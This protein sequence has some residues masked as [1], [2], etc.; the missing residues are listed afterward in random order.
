MSH[1]LWSLYKQLHVESC[2]QESRAKPNQPTLT[3]V[4]LKHFILFF[5][6]V[7]GG[8]HQRV[9]IWSFSVCFWH[10]CLCKCP[11]V[12]VIISNFLSAALSNFHYFIFLCYCWPILNRTN[13][14]S[15]LDSLA[16]WS[17]AA[18]AR[19]ATRLRMFIYTCNCVY[20]TEGILW[21]SQNSCTERISLWGTAYL[22]SSLRM[23][24]IWLGLPKGS[25]STSNWTFKNTTIIRRDWTLL[26]KM[27]WKRAL[28]LGYQM[29]MW[30]SANAQMRVGVCR[31]KRRCL[32]NRVDPSL[33]H[34][35]ENNQALCDCDDWQFQCDNW[36]Q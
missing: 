13:L 34:I 36:F 11:D 26:R 30:C 20:D 2:C 22:F 35:S 1:N 18:C 23:W 8:G 31:G 28:C 15:Y 29:Q 27:K 17:F 24:S 6:V 5:W 7:V 21:W 10:E 3:F 33:N 25:R 32:H 14:K 19:L 12:E 4:F 16:A 9:H